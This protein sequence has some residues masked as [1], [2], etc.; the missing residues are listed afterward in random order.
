MSLIDIKQFDRKFFNGQWIAAGASVAVRE[1]ATGA[2]LFETGQAG[3]DDIAA[4]AKAAR[5][6]QREWAAKP[7]EERAAIFRK[8]ADLLD[9][10]GEAITPLEGK[11]DTGRTY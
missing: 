6:T 5:A 8:A 2:T 7:N 11:C 4:A 3:K 9:Q 1:P 10:H